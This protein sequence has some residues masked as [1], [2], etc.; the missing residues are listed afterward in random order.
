M[1]SVVEG[2]KY[3]QAVMCESLGSVRNSSGEDRAG[4]GR[5]GGSPEQ[6]EPSHTLLDTHHHKPVRSN[7][8]TIKKIKKSWVVFN[9]WLG[10][11]ETNPTTGLQINLCWNCPF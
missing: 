11:K 9:S 7:D 3:S 4:G 2:L 10:Q 6:L 5:L 8:F 1:I